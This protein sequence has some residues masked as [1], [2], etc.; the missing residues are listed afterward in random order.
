[1]PCYGN[2]DRILEPH[3]RN[4][5]AILS[6]FLQLS[7]AYFNQI[8]GKKNRKVLNTFGTFISA[9]FNSSFKVAF[10]LF[11]FILKLSKVLA[12]IRNFPC[13]LG[14]S[15]TCSRKNRAVGCCQYC[16][17]RCRRIV[18][19]SNQYIHVFTV[20]LSSNV[21]E[22]PMTTHIALQI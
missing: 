8:C 19:W 6:Y 15:D 18:L 13:Y 5:L 21:H 7:L 12:N 14:H 22:L 1:M 4:F 17:V 11:V 10:N 9:F 20:D 3:S 16:E 2:Q